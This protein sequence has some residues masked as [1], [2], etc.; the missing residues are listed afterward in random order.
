M[1]AGR[2]V[3]ACVAALAMYALCACAGTRFS[4]DRVRQVQVGMTEEDL[5]RLLGRPYMVTSKG[6]TQ[7]WI[8]SYANGLTGSSKSVSFSV[9]EGKVSEVPAVPK[10]FK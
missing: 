1:R 4:Y 2:S 3:A 5:T 8:W 6:D 10:S 7:I 9:K